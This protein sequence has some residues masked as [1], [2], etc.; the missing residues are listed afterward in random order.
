MLTR[1]TPHVTSMGL[2]WT[3]FTLTTCCLFDRYDLNDLIESTWMPVACNLIQRIS[4][5]SVSNVFCKSKNTIPVYLPALTS[6]HLWSNIIGEVNMVSKAWISR[7]WASE[8][9]FQA[10]DHF[11]LRNTLFKLVI[12]LHCFL[13]HFWNNIKQRCQGQIYC[14]SWI[15]VVLWQISY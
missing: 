14:S 10:I 11:F 7:V 13:R 2:D 4:W 6:N 1:E 9:R 8:T 5:S 3:W 12:G 15:R